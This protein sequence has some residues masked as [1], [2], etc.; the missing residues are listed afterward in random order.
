MN[1]LEEKEN[2]ASHY[3]VNLGCEILVWDETGE[4]SDLYRVFN[5]PKLLSDI[6][7][8]ELDLLYANSMEY[9]P[10]ENYHDTLTQLIKRVKIGG[11]IVFK[12]TNLGHVIKNILRREF[13]PEMYNS[14]LWNGKK[15]G[16]TC[17]RFKTLLSQYGKINEIKMEGL[18]Y[19]VT[20]ERTS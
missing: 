19:Y 12:I 1:E 2:E 8:G 15:S 13:E 16:V 6:D 4:K 9:I 17:D 14:I 10:L 7:L 18:N 11:E 5:F 3:D 20:V